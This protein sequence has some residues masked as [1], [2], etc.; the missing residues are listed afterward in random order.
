MNVRKVNAVH[1]DLLG[2]AEDAELARAPDNQL[3]LVS[4]RRRKAP[5]GRMDDVVDVELLKAQRGVEVVLD[6]LGRLP[7]PH[8][9]ASI[10]PEAIYISLD[11]QG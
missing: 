5:S 8:F 7:Q 9:V 2:S 11:C 1:A 4:D 3:V 6:S 10:G